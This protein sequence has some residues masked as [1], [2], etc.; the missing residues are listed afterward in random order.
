MDLNRFSSRFAF[1]IGELSEWATEKD[2][3]VKPEKTELVLF[4]RKYEVEN[5]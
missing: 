3:G 2:F 4:T 5:F 1:R